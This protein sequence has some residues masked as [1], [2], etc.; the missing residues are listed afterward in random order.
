MMIGVG[1]KAITKMLMAR[2]CMRRSL[3][4]GSMFPYVYVD[5]DIY[6]D[7]HSRVSWLTGKSRVAGCLGGY[8]R[9]HARSRR[10]AVPPT[11]GGGGGNGWG[12]EEEMERI[13]Q[14]RW[15][16]DVMSLRV[17]VESCHGT[18]VLAAYFAHECMAGDV[19]LLEGDVG[20]GKSFFWY[21]SGVCMCI[22]INVYVCMCIY[23]CVSGW[24]GVYICVIRYIRNL[25]LPL[26]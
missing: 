3:L 12:V 19:V 22:Y 7:I 13:E 1:Q 26:L 11:G 2:S 18:A 8:H 10:P 24:V 6:M 4:M 25:P 15:G 17:M 14:E 9:K 23:K 16:G 20:A 5:R 21:V